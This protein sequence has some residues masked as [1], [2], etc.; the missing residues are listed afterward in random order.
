MNTKIS[1]LAWTVLFGSMLLGNA[2]I[3]QFTPGRRTAGDPYL[4]TI[5]NG[6]YDVQHYDLTIN[7]DPVANA[8]ISTAELTIEAT[9]TLSEF[10]LDLRGFTNATV[11]VDGWRL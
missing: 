5:G 9:Q 1:T 7:Y 8:M 10:S 3:A 2:V 6:G 4:P 11:S